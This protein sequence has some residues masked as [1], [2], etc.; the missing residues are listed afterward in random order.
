ML[1]ILKRFGIST[2][3]LVDSDSSSLPIEHSKYN[4][5]DATKWYFKIYGMYSFEWNVWKLWSCMVLIGNLSFLIYCVYGLIRDLIFAPRYLFWLVYLCVCFRSAAVI[6]AVLK[7]RNRISV[8]RDPTLTDDHGIWSKALKFSK[9]F[10]YYS[11]IGVLF[12][13]LLWSL[14]GELRDFYWTVINFLFF[15]PGGL[16]I[17]CYYAVI[18]HFNIADAN[19]S[20]HWIRELYDLAKTEELTFEQFQ[21]VRDDVKVLVDQSSS[22]NG[23]I[24]LGILSNFFGAAFLVLTISHLTSGLTAALSVFYLM[25][26]FVFLWYSEILFLWWLLPSLAVVNDEVLKLRSLI[27]NKT[28]S[29]GEKEKE[30]HNILL[31]MISENI[32]FSI[33]EVTITRTRIRSGLITVIVALLSSFIRAFISIIIDHI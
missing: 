7:L 19:Q 9:S 11:L 17:T 3:F 26:L 10:F 25:F 14:A 31:C 27:C 4:S 6:N 5:I 29:S 33:F 16:C 24:L 2:E 12:I 22:A 13:N 21:K 23:F 30:R 1:R 15:L 20:I 32:N 18:L 28:W 8:V